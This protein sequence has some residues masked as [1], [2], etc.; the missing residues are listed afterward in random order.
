MT[1]V[2]RQTTQGYFSR[3]TPRTDEHALRLLCEQ[4]YH[5]HQ[6]LWRL[7]AEHGIQQ[8]D[9]LY[10]ICETGPASY[11][12]VVSQR[13]PQ[14]SQPLWQ[15]TTKTYAP[16]LV[17]NQKLVF[18]LRANPVITRRSL[19]NAKTARHDVVMDAKVHPD[20][21][22]NSSDPVRTAGLKW[23][24]ERAARCGFR[25]E[26]LN[27]DGYRQHKLHKRRGKTPVTFSTLDFDGILTVT[28][29][30]LLTQ[31]LFN[32]LGPAK[33]FGCGLMLVKP[34]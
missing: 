12:Y 4:G 13:P 15:V 23:L 2:P 19:S 31:T 5:L 14:Q 10:R 22:A 28:D 11:L 8:R 6:T 3:V 29:G 1:S 26:R 25:V 27:I 9:F 32:G 18:S 24:E 16:K 33:G 21:Y 7:F 30:G 17:I 34:A 20:R